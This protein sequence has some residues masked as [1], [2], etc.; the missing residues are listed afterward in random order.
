MNNKM[1][2]AFGLFVF[3]V[4][5][6]ATLAWLTE[7]EEDPCANP[8]TDISAAVLG[9]TEGDQEGLLNRA[10]IVRGDCEPRDSKSED[11]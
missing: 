4:G 9:D 5:G 10:I 7:E 2:L 11:Q 8:Q 6:I 1:L 3:V